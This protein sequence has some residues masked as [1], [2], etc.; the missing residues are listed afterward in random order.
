MPVPNG[1]KEAV[2]K[3]QGR[4]GAGVGAGARERESAA[5]GTAQCVSAARGARAS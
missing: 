5:R 4:G 3:L 2:Q 1:S